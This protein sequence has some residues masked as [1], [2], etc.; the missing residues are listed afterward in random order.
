MLLIILALSGKTAAYAVIAF[1]KNIEVT[2]EAFCQA[3]GWIPEYIHA[4]AWIGLDGK[5][6]S[7]PHSHQWE[8]YEDLF[9][10]AEAHC[11]E[12]GIK[13]S[14]EGSGGSGG[15]NIATVARKEVDA[16]DSMENPEGS[17]NIKYNTWRYGHPVSG[18]DYMWCANFVAWC[19]NECGYVESCLFNKS[20]DV[21]GVYEYQTEVNGFDSYLGSEI[22]QL[23]GHDYQAVPGDIFCFGFSHIGIVTAVTENSIEITQGNTNNRVLALTYTKVSLADPTVSNGYIIHVLYPQDENTIFYFLTSQ[24]GLNTAAAA[25]VCANVEQESNF[26]PNALGDNGSSYGICQWHNQRW[27]NLKGF[28]EANNFDWQSMDGQLWF[29]KYELET[30]YPEVFDFLENIFDSPEGAYSAAYRWCTDYEIPA[31]KE[32]K[33]HIRGESAKNNYYPKYVSA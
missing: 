33:A 27:E 10:A 26:N 18:D 2:Q 7:R 25:G 14:G 31:D 28:C 22:K 4:A 1:D 16:P 6:Y 12:L 20:E 13:L 11:I 17:N 5:D 3:Y 8:T 32:T 9:K 15:Y 21:K 23:G 19:A 30:V 24:I 29:L